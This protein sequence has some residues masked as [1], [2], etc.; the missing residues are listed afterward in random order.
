MDVFVKELLKL[1]DIEFIV[2]SLEILVYTYKEL[3]PRYIDQML[4]WTEGHDAVKK[5]A[6]IKFSM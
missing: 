2:S 6:I 5:I 1:S 4:H 3:I